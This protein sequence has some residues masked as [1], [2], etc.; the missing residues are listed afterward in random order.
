M[1]VVL[2]SY[3]NAPSN[4]IHKLASHS[5][6][7]V[8][9]PVLVSSPVIT[10]ERFVEIVKTKSQGHLLA[11]SERLHLETAIT[12]A[13]VELGNKYVLYSVAGNSG[14][15]FSDRGLAALVK[16]SEGS[17]RIAE[18]V[19]LRRDLPATLFRSLLSKVKEEVRIRILAGKSD[20]PGGINRF[21]GIG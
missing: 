17:D 16:A 7:A 9:R 8:A 20:V 4:I 12:D 1:S 21:G 11:V 15:R 19:G 6:I 13:L 14:A 10:T 5:E 18:K 3:M 2:A